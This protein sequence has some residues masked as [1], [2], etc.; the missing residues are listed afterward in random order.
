MLIIKV[1]DIQ[2]LTF[3]SKLADSEFGGYSTKG[4]KSES[5]IIVLK[6][7]LFYPDRF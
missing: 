3:S 1:A 4:D 5:I 7:N 6:E 2:Q